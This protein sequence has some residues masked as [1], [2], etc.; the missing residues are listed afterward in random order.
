MKQESHN[1]RAKT[2]PQ[3]P[4]LFHYPFSKLENLTPHSPLQ[5]HVCDQV[6]GSQFASLTW[7]SET[8]T[9]RLQD[10]LASTK[11]AQEFLRHSRE[12]RESSR[13]AQVIV[14]VGPRML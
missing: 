7:S 10:F 4:S 8:Q 3:L 14:P 12:S 5:N 11:V 9:L 1:D 6:Q 13:D 2:F